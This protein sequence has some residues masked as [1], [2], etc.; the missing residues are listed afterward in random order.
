MKKRIPIERLVPGMYMIEMDRPWWQTPF[1][2]HRRM[3]STQ[4]EIDQLRGHGIAEVVIDTDRG[5]DLAVAAPSP[6][7]QPDPAPA[8]RAAPRADRLARLAKD[9]EIVQILWRDA[10]ATVQRVFEGVREGAPLDHPALKGTVEAFLSQ[11]VERPVAMMTMAQLQQ[12]KRLDRDMFG[13]AVD[14]CVLSLLVAKTHGLGAPM[15]E[16]LGLGAL[17]HDIGELRLPQNMFNRKGAFTEKERALMQSHPLLGLAMLLDMPDIPEDTR[18]IV[19]EHHERLD[20]SGYP[21]ALIGGQCSLPAQI[22]GLVDVYDALASGRN[23]RPPLSPS[24]AVR[25][26]YQLGLQKRHTA[27]LV[28]RMIQVLGVYP[29]GSLVE[30]NTGER[31]VVFSPNPDERLKPVIKLLASDETPRDQ[32]PR[33]L[34]L[35]SQPEDEPLRFIMR[36]LDPEKEGVDPTPYCTL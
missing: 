30:L 36:I 24:Q 8:Q 23:G 3:L 11:L 25:Q 6:P 16:A 33:I 22:V 35:S 26:L 27:W 10:Q 19:G 34:D 29:F 32:P 31:A 28:E 9:L 17:L 2:N 21:N 1:W 13:H 18:R 15:L 14:V 7:D 20:G 4:T 5:R 12:M